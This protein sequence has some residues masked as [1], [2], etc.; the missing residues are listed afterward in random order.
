MHRVA[1][2]FSSSLLVR[3]GLINQLA[4]VAFSVQRMQSSSLSSAR[5]LPALPTPTI[6]DIG[7]ALKAKLAYDLTSMDEGIQAEEAQ[8]DSFFKMV[9]CLCFVLATCCVDAN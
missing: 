1:A 5:M 6:N 7:R 4:P 8:K 9:S 2:G 3:R